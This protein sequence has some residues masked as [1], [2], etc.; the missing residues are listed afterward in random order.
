M[1]SIRFGRVLPCYSSVT[2]CSWGY[3]DDGKWCATT[4]EPVY[5]PDDYSTGVHPGFTLS[6][7]RAT[8]GNVSRKMELVFLSD[9]TEAQ[10]PEPS[11]EQEAAIVRVNDRVFKEIE[12][13][14]DD[15][16]H[17]RTKQKQQEGD[18]DFDDEEWEKLALLVDDKTGR[19]EEPDPN[20]LEKEVFEKERQVELK[21]AQQ[22]DCGDNLVSI[23]TREGQDELPVFGPEEW[24]EL[25]TYID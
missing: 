4:F 8:V 16:Y 18:V 10:G 11:F 21:A 12:A 6:R 25:A 17:E 13:S 14:G 7:A 15:L 3:G 19:L 1:A 2:N 24:N 5:Y 23:F 9:S 22:D 20:I